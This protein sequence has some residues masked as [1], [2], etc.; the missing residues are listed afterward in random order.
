MSIYTTKSWMS[1]HVGGIF[2]D[3]TPANKAEIL[4]A[5]RSRVGVHTTWY[6]VLVCVISYIVRDYL[7]RT[8]S[9][10]G[11]DPSASKIRK[12]PRTGLDSVAAP[13]VLKQ[14]RVS[15]S[16]ISNEQ[17]TAPNILTR[18]LDRRPFPLVLPGSSAKDT[19]H[20]KHKPASLIHCR[21]LIK[22]AL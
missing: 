17:G 19:L 15:V 5:Q 20:P 13:W 9:S 7:A 10:H 14:Y 12:S 18:C 2:R 22:I 8:F 1:L 6:S 3:L 4:A 11:A 16:K 21:F